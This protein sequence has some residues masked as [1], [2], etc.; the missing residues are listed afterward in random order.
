VSWE[1]VFTRGSRAYM[2]VL[3]DRPMEKMTP[4]RGQGED[5]LLAVVVRVTAEKGLRGVTFR[6]VAE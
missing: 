2:V 5:A 6:A 3:Y 1:C 4:Q